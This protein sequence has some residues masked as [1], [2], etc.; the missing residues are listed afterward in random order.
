MGPLHDRAYRRLFSHPE[1]VEHLLRGYFAEPWVEEIDFG[2]LERRAESYVTDAW[3]GRSQDVVWRAVAAVCAAL[4][5]ACY[6]TW[7]GSP[8]WIS[9]RTPIG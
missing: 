4:A 1:M 7:P 5:L 9:K 2:S 6:S 3:G 8:Q